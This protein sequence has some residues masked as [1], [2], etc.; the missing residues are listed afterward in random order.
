MTNTTTCN[1]CGE[2]I[3]RNKAKCAG[4]ELPFWEGAT[5]C[6]GCYAA[7]QFRMRA[8]EWSRPLEAYGD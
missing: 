5:L 7:E 2:E 6:H 1:R 3:D 8:D 4:P